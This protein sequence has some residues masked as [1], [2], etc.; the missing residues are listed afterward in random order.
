MELTLKLDEDAPVGPLG[1][2][3]FLITGDG[4]SGRIPLQVE[5][6]VQPPIV[7]RPK[8]ISLGTIYEGDQITRP[9][10]LT[11]DNPFLVNEWTTSNDYVTI[12]H[13]RAIQTETETTQIYRLSFTAPNVTETKSLRETVVFETDNPDISPTLTILAVVK[14]R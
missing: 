3:I 1:G 7:I 5:G 9:I 4:A 6:E 11:G 2:N 8:D 12:S 13:E 14:P 10:F